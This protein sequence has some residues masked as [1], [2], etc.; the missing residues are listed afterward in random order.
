VPRTS[1]E[2]GRTKPLRYDALEAK[3]AGVAKYY[4][5]GLVYV[6][7]EMQRPSAFAEQLG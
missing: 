1:R 7:I 3:L 5:A 4:V 2:I 6:I